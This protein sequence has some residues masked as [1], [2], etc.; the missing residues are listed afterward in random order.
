MKRIISFIIASLCAV[1]MAHAQDKLPADAIMKQACEEAAKEKKNVFLLFHASWCGWC[2]RMDNSMNDEDCKKFFDD[3]YVIRHMVVDESANK[4]D[5]ETPGAA[6]LRTKYHGDNQGIPY[7]LV[8]D[9]D[10]K[11]LA[12]SKMR[13]EGEGPEAGRNTGCPAHPEEVAHF[14]EVLKK[15]TKLNAEQLA[16]IQKRFRKNAE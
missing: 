5:L 13:N 16:I 12:D 11:L 3:N 4:K 9:K 10:G 1:M 6:E 15:T 8:F 2:H 7:W 14:I